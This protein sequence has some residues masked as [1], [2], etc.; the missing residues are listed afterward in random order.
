[1]FGSG[2]NNGRVSCFPFEGRGEGG[3]GG[4]ADSIKGQR[5][6]RLIF[7]NGARRDGTITS[8]R[9]NLSG[10]GRRLSM[11][12]KGGERER[13][14]ERRNEK[15]EGRTNEWRERTTQRERERNERKKKR[16]R[17]AVDE[18]IGIHG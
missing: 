17:L 2:W 6:S 11:D 9:E 14:R 16:Y 8:A 18:E 4:Q 3:I 15:K 7:P 12:R 1:M 13:E 5:E 10:N